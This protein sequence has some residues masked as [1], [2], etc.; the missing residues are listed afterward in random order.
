MYKLSQKHDQQW[1]ISGY[2]IPV[3]YLDHIKIADEKLHSKYANNEVKRPKPNP[4]D[5]KAVRALFTNELEKKDKLKPEP[6]KYS[7]RLKWLKGY[8]A[9]HI[10]EN[11][12]PAKQE[13]AFKWLNTPEDK[14]VIEKFERN[15]QK[16]PDLS[17]QKHTFIEQIIRQNSKTE[18][19][20]PG[21][22]NYFLDK[23]SAQKFFPEKQELVL[24]KSK[25]ENTIAQ[26][27]LP[28]I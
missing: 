11:I 13:M 23:K 28:F 4:V 21:P 8:Q 27:K 5:L 10:K 6:W 16:K 1:G 14:K 24:M 7:I 26:G 3:K 15:H 22:G 17:V 2:E 12:Q 20:K 18:Y 9:S 25:E 19:P